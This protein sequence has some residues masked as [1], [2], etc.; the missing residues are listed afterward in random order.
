M[1][2]I[3]ILKDDLRKVANMKM[4][5]STFEKLSHLKINF[6]KGIFLWKGHD[7]ENEHTHNYLAVKLALPRFATMKFPSTSENF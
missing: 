6:H 2:D 7:E 1:D 5:M 3:I 4:V